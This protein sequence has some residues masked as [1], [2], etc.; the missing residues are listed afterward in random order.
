MSSSDLLMPR[1]SDSMDEGTVLG[2]MKSLG[3]QVEVGEELVEIETDK[4]S[5]VLQAAVSGT[6][7][8]IVAQEGATI[9]VGQAIARI[10]DSAAGSSGTDRDRNGVE[11]P[12]PE[13]GTDKRTATVIVD[14]DGPV[15]AEPSNDSARASG[16]APSTDGRDKVKASPL[17]RRMAGEANVDLGTV[18]GTGPGG[19]ITRSDIE[20]V[21]APVPRDLPSSP[22]ELA[23]SD[24]D[25]RAGV[26]RHPDDLATSSSLE[27]AKGTTE[28]VEPTRLQKTVGRRM[29][30]SKATAPHFYL[31]A[32]ID[33]SR[34]RESRDRLKAPAHEDEVVPSF[35]DLIV[36]ASALALREIPHANGSYRD[37]RFELYSRVNVG[38]VVAAGD[39]LVVPTIFDADSRGLRE[40]ASESQALAQRVREGK[41]TPAELS[42]G[43][44]TVSNLG[45]YG[46]KNIVPVIN[47]PQAAIL[48]VGAIDERPIIRCGQIASAHLMEVTL[49]CD[50]RILRGA[51]GA[52]LLNRIRALLE[53]PLGLAK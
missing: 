45:M 49:A 43:T 14:A 24:H 26:A 41:I 28:L 4:A 1:L 22:V 16:P 40:I 46:M 36:K 18:G 7:L 35:N 50:H 17:A 39:S 11:R 25:A 19:R 38:I 12:R 9:R 32:E 10:G 30:A 47:S 52:E 8:E 31:Q 51:D 34:C 21:L 3:D 5:M 42:G 27:A 37:G 23:E 6:L 20:R 2:W 33:M 15:E 53:E 29:V 48:G 44:F 13:E